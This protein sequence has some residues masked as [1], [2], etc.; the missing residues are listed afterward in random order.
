VVKDGTARMVKIVSGRIFGEN[1]EVL[2][3]LNNGEIVVTSGQINLT[4]GTKV[5][6]IK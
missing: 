4:D 5:N 2:D 3:G 6:P 1:V